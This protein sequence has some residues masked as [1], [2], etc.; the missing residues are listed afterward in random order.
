MMAPRS[1]MV[2][3]GAVLASVL[4]AG[5]NARD[6]SPHDAGTSRDGS[7]HPPG[8]RPSLPMDAAVSSGTDAAPPE[9]SQTPVERGE[10]LVRHL[11]GCVECHS[12]R[13]PSGQFDESRLLSG[14]VNLDDLDPGDP[15]RGAIH[16]RN[17]TPDART[18]LG[19]W[20]D[21]EIKDAFQHGM[22]RDGRVLHW[23]MPYF[24]YHEMTE[25]DADAVVAYLRSLPPVENA[26]PDRQPLPVEL[27][28]PYHLPHGI[29]P[30][31]TLSPGHP[32]YGRTLRGKYLAT[33]AGLCLF[34]HTARAA[35]PGLPLDLERL[36]MGRREML[37]VPLGTVVEDDDVP[38]IQT[39]NLTPHDTGL[40]AWSA[41][42][43]ANAIR[44][45]VSRD[46]LPVCDPMPSNFGGS[47]RGVREQDA[48]DIGLYLTTLPPRDSGEIAACCSACH[49]PMADGDA[50][51][52]DA[53]GGCL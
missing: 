36:L 1:N 25:P 32:D 14:V 48:L 21:A 16:A 50:G 37:P 6:P 19:A 42:D 28:E 17:L 15:Q 41:G 44:L 4:V 9:S 51:A 35:D 31:S 53:D 11:S 43:V 12:P 8:M 46:T 5:C 24:I 34:C 13:L 18:G 47:L 29:V 7:A 30:D 23:S 20:S 27:E 49:G 3:V 40:G 52:V 39:R 2:S 10:Y 22:A 38:R 45:G 26:I 33:G